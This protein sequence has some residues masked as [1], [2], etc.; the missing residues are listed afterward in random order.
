MKYLIDTPFFIDVLK[1]GSPLVARYQRHILEGDE[2]F[3]FCLVRYEILRGYH[4]TIFC[5]KG[6][7]DQK[8]R[9]RERI[10]KFEKLSDEFQ[11]IFLTDNHLISEAA[12]IYGE[13]ESI[14]YSNIPDID[15]FLVAIGKGNDYTIV[16]T[17]GHVNRLAEH[18]GILFDNWHENT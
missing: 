12:E 4:K 13:I 7:A 10:Q 18:Y 3:L 9:E 6:N 1:K 11:M 8:E 2:L 16:S 14:G 17:D 15:I 5:K